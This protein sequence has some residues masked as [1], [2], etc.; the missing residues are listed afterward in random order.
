MVKA[1]ERRV[2]ITGKNA[3]LK[4]KRNVI[5]EVHA[6]RVSYISFIFI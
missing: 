5:Q 6:M 3:T 2:V 1:V 4:T